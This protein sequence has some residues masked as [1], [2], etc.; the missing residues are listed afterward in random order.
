MHRLATLRCSRQV[1][2]YVSRNPHPYS[3]GVSGPV[4]REYGKLTVAAVVLVLVWDCIHLPAR[5]HSRAH[6]LRTGPTDIREAHQTSMIRDFV[7]SILRHVQSNAD[8]TRRGGGKRVPRN[9]LH[10]SKV[11]PTRCKESLLAS[12]ICRSLRPESLII[13]VMCLLPL[14]IQP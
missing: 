14:S 10:H 7:V 5:G 1:S 6:G 11:N 8:L 4:V 12:G 13:L 3:A 2:E 9:W